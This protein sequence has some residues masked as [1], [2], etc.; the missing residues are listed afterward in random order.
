MNKMFSINADGYVFNWHGG[1]YV[2]VSHE[3]STQ[4]F[5][6]INVWDYEW[7]VPRIDVTIDG[8]MKVVDEWLRELS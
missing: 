4:P 8:L 6:V 5:D 2:E 3:G 7:D 1:A